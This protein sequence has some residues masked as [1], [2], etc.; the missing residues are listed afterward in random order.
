MSVEKLSFEQCKEA[1][2]RLEGWHFSRE[3]EAIRREYEFSDFKQAF[4]FMT[5]VAMLAEKA[6]HHPEWSNVYNRVTI[7]L[8]THDAKGLSERDFKLAEAIDTLRL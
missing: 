3:G 5:R 2:A 6:D 4:S 7:E 8:T 1:I